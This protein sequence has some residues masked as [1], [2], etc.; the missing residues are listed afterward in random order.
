MRTLFKNLGEMFVQVS[1]DKA[2]LL[3]EIEKLYKEKSE[4][5]LEGTDGFL[6]FVSDSR[7]WAFQYIEEVQKAL[8]EFDEKIIPILEWE[9]TY[10]T[11]NG[12][13]PHLEHMKEISEAYN[14]LKKVLP[15]ETETPNN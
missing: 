1:Q 2:V 15:Q 7:D 13:N 3:H 11:V 6:K 8:S 5:E 4:K 10:G 12:N 9:K 14:K